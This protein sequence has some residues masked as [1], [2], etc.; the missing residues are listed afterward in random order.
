MTGT[1]IAGIIHARVHA[2]TISK[3]SAPIFGGVSIAW[4]GLDSCCE[5]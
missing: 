3:F 1:V 5:M 2:A 4:K